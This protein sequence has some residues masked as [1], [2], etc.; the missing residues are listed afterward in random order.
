MPRSG[1]QTSLCS[2]ISWVP[3]KVLV[4]IQYRRLYQSQWRLHKV[5]CSVRYTFLEPISSRKS[6]MCSLSLFRSM[7]AR[8]LPTL[9]SSDM[10]TSLICSISPVTFLE[11]RHDTCF[12]PVLRYFLGFLYL[13]NELVQAVDKLSTTKFSH[14]CWNSIPSWSITILRSP[15]RCH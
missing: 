13:L 1:W 2:H 11:K 6:E 3:A 15:D 4:A 10:A 9:A 7:C 5:A 8:I 14:F 12:L